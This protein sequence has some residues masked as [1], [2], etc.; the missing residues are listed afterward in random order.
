MSEKPAM[1]F[2]VKYP[3]ITSIALLVAVLFFIRNLINELDIFEKSNKALVYLIGLIV[4]SLT[5]VSPGII[6]SI[7]VLL[8]C[9]YV[10]DKTGFVIGGLG[11]IYFVIMFYYG[12]DFNLLIKSELL[13]A[14]GVIFGGIYFLSARKLV[15]DEKN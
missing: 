2:D 5:A 12:L 3:W 8:L 4:L 15:R 6:G 14:T 7:L 1:Q 9:F 13:L 11:L 10:N